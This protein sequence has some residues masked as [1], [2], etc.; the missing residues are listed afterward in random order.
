MLHNEFIAIFVILIATIVS[1]V[2]LRFK[3]TLAA[4]ALLFCTLV[5]F[6]YGWTI[7]KNNK[8]N[9]SHKDYTNNQCLIGTTKQIGGL[10]QGGCYD[11]WMVYHVL[12]WIIIGLLAP[13]YLLIAA[14]ISICWELFEHIM[15]KYVYKICNAQV[16]GRIED[17]VTNVV[18][19]LIGSYISTRY[20]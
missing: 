3:S 8:N 11:V 6:L 7:E 17:V 19:Y 1:L 14:I 20:I 10:L 18:G 12:Y 9:K 16:C 5:G 4:I 2:I 13:G 15:F